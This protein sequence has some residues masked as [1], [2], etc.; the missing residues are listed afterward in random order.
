M[1]I[2]GYGPGVRSRTSRPTTCWRRPGQG[3]NAITGSWV[4]PPNRGRRW[5]TC[6]RDLFSA[7]SILSLLL[8]VANVRAPA[9]VS[10]HGRAQV[11]VSLFDTMTELTSTRSPPC[12]PASTRNRGNGL[13]A[14]G[15][16]HGS[17]RHRRRPDR[18][19]RHD[20]RS[21]MAAAVLARSSA[22]TTS[23][24]TAGTHRT[25][26]GSPTATSSTR[27]SQTGAPGHDLAGSE[28]ADAAGIS[29]ARQQHAERCHR[30]PWH[31]RARPLA[32]HRHRRPRARLLPPAVVAGSNR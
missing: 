8:H 4:R 6:H 31:L 16:V 29:N 23:P 21:R 30:P 19:A 5:P 28:S 15:I 17:Y 22:A 1:E 14:V 25:R 3:V 20:E 10:R 2:D 32:N 18:G 9:T 26:T 27:R 11:Q 13:P 12:T 7:I 24:M